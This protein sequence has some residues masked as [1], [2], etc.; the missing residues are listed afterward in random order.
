MSFLQVTLDLINDGVGSEFEGYMR[1]LLTDF[2]E[3]P[4][5]GWK[6]CIAA[7]RYSTDPSSGSL[8]SAARALRY[9]HVWEVQDLNTLPKLMDDFSDNSTYHCLDALVAAET[10]DFCGD[11]YPA[12]Y[13]DPASHKTLLRLTTHLIQD[14]VFDFD[15]FMGELQAHFHWTSFGWAP[16]HA[17]YA[18]TGK[19]RSYFHIWSTDAGQP[20]AEGAVEWLLNQAKFYTALDPASTP[21]LTWE[22]WERVSY[23]Q[24]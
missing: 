12:A 17:S 14:K 11:C 8:S 4:E 1:K 21:A 5:P 22:Q 24:G 13:P 15:T 18:Q 19:L 16:E 10:Q 6:L 2:T 23:E 7:K 3:T 9:L 20:D